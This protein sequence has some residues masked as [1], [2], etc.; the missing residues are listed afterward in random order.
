MWINEQTLAIFTLH[1]DIRYECYKDNKLM[2]AILDDNILAANGYALVA[3]VRPIFD[4]ITQGLTPQVP[5]K[6]EDGKWT[7]GYDVVELDPAI[8][9]NNRNKILA[10]HIQSVKVEIREGNQDAITA[11]L[12]NDTAKIDAWKIKLVELQA[13]LAALEAQL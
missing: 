8:V 4:E 5:V 11:M 13:Q 7:L 10:M 9:A 3:Q 6:G 1:S 12:Q 2:P